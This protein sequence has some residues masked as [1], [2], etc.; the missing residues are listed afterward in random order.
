VVETQYA[1]TLDNGDQES[2]FLWTPDLL[3]PGYP[4]TP[5]GQLGFASDLASILAAVPGGRGLG[6]FYW[7]P[8]W[9]PGIGWQ[10]GAGTPN[11]NLTLFDFGGHALPGVSFA[12]P[13]C[14]LRAGAGRGLRA[15]GGAA[16]QDAAHRR[17]LDEHQRP[18]AGIAVDAGEQIGGQRRVRGRPHDEH[19]VV[20]ALEQDGAILAERE[21][22]RARAPAGEHVGP[23]RGEPL[24]GLDRVGAAVLAARAQSLGHA[25]V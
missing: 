19:R 16:R 4:A 20:G 14:A 3:V 11:D 18:G 22:P 25:V 15:L 8:E 6:I 2:N 24:A 23:R 5:D 17:A 1:W 10:P 7:Q 21:V 13:L 9:I 12:D